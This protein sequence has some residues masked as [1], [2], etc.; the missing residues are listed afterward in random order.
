MASGAEPE[1][2]R[3]DSRISVPMH[4]IWQEPKTE[5]IDTKIVPHILNQWHYFGKSPQLKETDA[6]VR[7]VV[8]DSR[9]L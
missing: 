8:V 1:R 4:E 2:D 3:Y 5:R 7:D 9:H 6:T